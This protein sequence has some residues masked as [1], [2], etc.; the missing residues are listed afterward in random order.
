M[1]HRSSFLVFILILFTPTFATTS[2]GGDCAQWRGPNRDAKSPETGLLDTWPE[3]GPPL[4]WK[5][6]GVGGGY[7][8]IAIANG[9]IFTMGDLGDGSYVVALKESDGAHIW[10][11]RIGEAGGHK[12]YP[13][14]R[15]TPTIDG[16]EV[17]VLN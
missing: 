11:N 12:R 9:R 4:S 17:F 16:G 2:I 3:H 13:G 14:P 7:S 8:S 6:T 1:S 10:K 15:G 5:A